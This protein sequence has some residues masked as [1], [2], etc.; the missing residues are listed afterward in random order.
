MWT[1]CISMGVISGG[2]WG[3]SRTVAGT[4][5]R[6]RIITSTPDAATS[7]QARGQTT[8]HA[9]FVPSAPSTAAI[10]LSSRQD[11]PQVE[12][13]ATRGSQQKRARYA[14]TTIGAALYTQADQR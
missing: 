14:I 1:H 11:L 8:S 7:G 2:R 4:S 3:E 6:E 9:A 13:A 12:R 5:A 10:S